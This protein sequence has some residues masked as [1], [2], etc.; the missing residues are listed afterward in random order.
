[1]LS[2]NITPPLSPPRHTASPADPD[3]NSQAESNWLPKSL[4][5]AILGRLCAEPKNHKKHILSKP[6]KISKN[7]TMGTQMLDVDDLLMPFGHPFSS[8]FV[9][10]PNLLNCN[11]DCVK[12]LLS[13]LLASHFGIENMLKFMFFQDTLLDLI[14]HH[15]I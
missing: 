8:N 3:Q 2:G 4:I 14:F 13:P 9:T 11:K 7:S 6:H 12:T 1:M 15:F 10:H 5:I